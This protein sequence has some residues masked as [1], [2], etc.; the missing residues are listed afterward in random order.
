M[1]NFFQWFFDG[2]GTE[3]VSLIIGAIGGGL[4]GFHIGKRSKITQTQKAGNRA[5][6]RQESTSENKNSAD[7]KSGKSSSVK[8]TQ[9]AGDN[10]EQ[11]QIGGS[12]NG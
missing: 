10:S 4:A 11:V 1:D 6:Q 2:L 8:Q 3:I 12:K 7:K 5:K 9:V